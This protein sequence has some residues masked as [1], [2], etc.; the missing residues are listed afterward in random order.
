MHLRNGFR[1]A[2]Q[3]R[4]FDFYNCRVVLPEQGLYFFAVPYVLSGAEIPD[5]DRGYT[6]TIRAMVGRLQSP[7]L[8]LSAWDRAAGRRTPIVANFVGRSPMAASISL[9]KIIFA[10]PGLPRAGISRSS[11]I[12]ATA[13]TRLRAN[14]IT[15]LKNG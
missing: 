14:G 7:R 4:W 2:N 10:S 6:F 5:E 9:P 12:W 1:F 3:P 15:T 8:L 11:R 13:R